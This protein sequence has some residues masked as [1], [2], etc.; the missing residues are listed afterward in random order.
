MGKYNNTYDITDKPERLFP[1]VVSAH[2][3]SWFS[4]PLF[5]FIISGWTCRSW[6]LGS[7]GFFGSSAKW[8]WYRLV[9]PKCEQAPVFHSTHWLWPGRL[10]KKGMLGTRFCCGSAFLRPF[11]IDT[12]VSWTRVN[13]ISLLYRLIIL[14]AS[15]LLRN[16]EISA[17]SPPTVPSLIDLSAGA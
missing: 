9:V 13:Q 7:L 12:W 16:W 4:G 3:F 1:K 2:L 8:M 14:L 15:V 10:R 17:C 6:K 5:P 11:S